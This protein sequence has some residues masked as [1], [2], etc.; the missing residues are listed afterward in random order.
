MYCRNAELRAT[1]SRGNLANRKTTE[2]QLPQIGSCYF[3]KKWKTHSSA[4]SVLSSKKYKI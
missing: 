3:N 4:N 2:T 1:G